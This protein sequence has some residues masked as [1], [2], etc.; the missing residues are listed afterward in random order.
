MASSAQ[1]ARCCALHHFF[2]YY[3]LQLLAILI[4]SSTSVSHGSSYSGLGAARNGTRHRDRGPHELQ[5]GHAVFAAVPTAW[6]TTSWP[7]A[8]YGTGQLHSSPEAEVGTGVDSNAASAPSVASTTSTTSLS[9]EARYDERRVRQHMMHTRKLLQTGNAGGDRAALLAQKN[10]ITNQASIS[11]LTSWTADGDPCGFTFVSCSN[12][13]VSMLSMA[14][15]GLQG[16]LAKELGSLAALSYLELS[17]NQLSGTIPLQLESASFLQFLL[18]YQNQ[19]SGTIPPELQSL[20]SLTALYLYN[21]QLSGTIPTA[22]GAMA[23]M[24]YLILNGNGLSGTIPPELGSLSGLLRL[25]LS[26][27]QLSG[28]IPPELGSLRSLEWLLL[29]GNKLSG[30][31]PSALKS[32]SSLRFLEISG[33]QLSGTIPTELVSLTALS[34]LVL[35]SNLLSGTILPLRNFTSLQILDLSNNQLSGT[36]PDMSS[37]SSL[38]LSKNQLSG[39]I[40]RLPSTGLGYL[41]LSQNQL[42]G[43]IPR[44]LGIGLEWLYLQENRLVG[45]VP[46]NDGDAEINGFGYFM[47]AVNVAFNPWICGP[48]PNA[49]IIVPWPGEVNMTG[50]W[51][52]DCPLDTGASTPRPP[53]PLPPL[54][55]PPRPRSPPLFGLESDRAALLAQKDAFTDRYQERLFD[56]TIDRNPCGFTFVDCYD[57]ERVDRLIIFENDFEGTIVRQLGSLEALTI[58]ALN[59]NRLSGTIP[60]ELGSLSS[61]ATLGMQRNLKLS[62]TIPP[63]LQSL[64]SLGHLL[65]SDNQLSGTIPPELGTLAFLQELYLGGTSLSGT[66]PPELGSLTSLQHLSLYN[67]QL[68]GTIPDLSDLSLSYLDM[69]QNQLS[70]T[71]PWLAHTRVLRHLDLSRNQ[72]SGTIPPLVY[73]FR[74]ADQAQSFVEYVYLQENRLVGTV[75]LDDKGITS[76]VDVNVAFNPWICG[77]NEIRAQTYNKTGTWGLTCPVC[78]DTSS[79]LDL[80]WGCTLD[81]PS[82][83]NNNECSLDTG[84][85]TPRPP[86]PPPSPPP[87]SPPPPLNSPPRPRSPPLFGLAPPEASSPPP[88][89]ASSPPPPVAEMCSGSEVLLAWEEIEFRLATIIVSETV[90]LNP[91]YV[92]QSGTLC[93]DMAVCSVGG[94]AS[95]CCPCLE[96]QLTILEGPDSV[97]DLSSLIFQGC[98]SIG[99]CSLDSYLKLF[100][101]C[102]YGARANALLSAVGAPF[103]PPASSLPPRLAAPP[104]PAV[105]PPVPQSIPSGFVTDPSTPWPPSPPLPP[106]SP[107]PAPKSPPRSPSPPLFSPESDR[108]ALL[109]QRDAFTDRYQ[110]WLDDWTIDGNPCGFSYVDCSCGFIYVDCPITNFGRVDRLLLSENQFEGTIV[111]QLGSL[112]A[113]QILALGGNRLSGTIPPEL[114]SLSSLATLMME[115]NL[116]LSGTIPSELQSLASL[117]YL[118]LSDN[119]L[120]GTIPPELGALAFLYH[121]DLG[122]TLLSGTIPPELGSLTSLEYLDLSDTQLSGTIPPELGSLRSLQILWISDTVKLSGTFPPELGSSSLRQLD[123]S[124]N[125][126][127]GT[128]PAGLGS[129]SSLSDLHLN[130]NRIL[131]TIPALRSF[132]TLSRLKLYSNQLSGTIPDLSAH[133]RLQHID[134]S[135][136]Q[137]SGAIPP[138]SHM[139]GLGH[140]DLSRNQLSGTIPSLVYIYR[141]LGWIKVGVSDYVYLQENRLVGTV[142]LDDKNITSLVAVNVAFN[143]WICGGNEIRAQ[144]YNK[145]GTWGLTCPVCFDTASVSDLDWGCTLNAPVCSDNNACV[146]LTEPDCLCPEAISAIFSMAIPLSTSSPLVDMFI[147]DLVG[148]LQGLEDPSQ[149]V[150]L[151]LS[152]GRTIAELAFV[153][154]GKQ[155]SFPAEKD[156]HILLA[157]RNGQV[158][159][160]DTYGLISIQVPGHDPVCVLPPVT[161]IGLLGATSEGGAPFAGPQP[162]FSVNT[163]VSGLLTTTYVDVQFSRPCQ[164]VGVIRDCGPSGCQLKLGSN[165]TLVAGID[166]TH[167]AL[168]VTYVETDNASEDVSGALANG[169]AIDDWAAGSRDSF[170]LNVTIAE[171]ICRDAL[172]IASTASE[173]FISDKMTASGG[174]RENKLVVSL[175]YTISPSCGLGDRGYLRTVIYLGMCCV[176]H[177]SRDLRPMFPGDTCIASPE[178]ADSSAQMTVHTLSFARLAWDDRVRPRLM[179]PVGSFSRDRRVPVFVDLSGEV[180]RSFNASA[181]TVTAGY[182]MDNITTSLDGTWFNVTLVIDE[183]ATAIISLDEGALYDGLSGAPSRRSNTLSITHVPGDALTD[184]VAEVGVAIKAVVG[185]VAVLNTMAGALSSLGM[186]SPVGAIPA[187]PATTTGLLGGIGHL[188]TIAMIANLRMELPDFFEQTTARWRW[189]NL[190]F[191]KPWDGSVCSPKSVEKAMA[192]V[193]TN[194]TAT[195]DIGG[196]GPQEGGQG[197]GAWAWLQNGTS[198]APVV[199]TRPDE[200]SPSTSQVVLMSAAC[201]WDIALQI[202][203]WAVILIVALLLIH[204]LVIYG[205][206]YKFPHAAS[207]ELLRFPRIELYLLVIISPPLSQAGS[208]LLSM[209]TPLAV[210]IGV[211]MLLAGPCA[212]L[213]LAIFILSRHVLPGHATEFQREEVPRPARPAWMRPLEHIWY[214]LFGTPIKAQWQD[215]EH[216]SFVA[217]FGPVFEIFKGPPHDVGRKTA[218]F[219]DEGSCFGRMMRWSNRMGSHWHAGYGIVD[220]FKRVFVAFM[221]GLSG[222]ARSDGSEDNGGSSSQ[223]RWGA[224]VQVSTVL[225]VLVVQLAIVV[226]QRP[227]IDRFMQAAETLSV[228]CEVQLFVIIFLILG[229][230]GDKSRVSNALKVTMQLSIVCN[231]LAQLYASVVIFIGGCKAFMRRLAQARQR[232]NLDSLRAHGQDALDA[233]SRLGKSSRELLREWVLANSGHG[234]DDDGVEAHAAVNR[235]RLGSA[236]QPE[237]SGELTSEIGCT[238]VHS[239][240]QASPWVQRPGREQGNGAGPDIGWAEAP[241]ACPKCSARCQ[242]GKGYQGAFMAEHGASAANF[243]LPDAA[244]AGRDTSNLYAVNPWMSVGA[245]RPRTTPMEGLAGK[246]IVSLPSQGYWPPTPPLMMASPTIFDATRNSRVD[247]AIPH[248][249]NVAGDAPGRHQNH[250]LADEGG[251]AMASLGVEQVLMRDKESADRESGTVSGEVPPPHGAQ[252]DNGDQQSLSDTSV[253]RTDTLLNGQQAAAGFPQRPEATAHNSGPV[254]QELPLARDQLSG[255]RAGTGFETDK[256]KKRPRTASD[257]RAALRS[258]P[259]PEMMLLQT[260]GLF[261]DL[262]ALAR[263]LPTPAAMDALADFM[264]VALPQGMYCNGIAHHSVT[265]DPTPQPVNDDLCA[266]FQVFLAAQWPVDNDVCAFSHAGISGSGLPSRRSIKLHARLSISEDDFETHMAQFLSSMSSQLNNNEADINIVHVSAATPPTSTARSLRRARSEDLDASLSRSAT[267]RQV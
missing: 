82:C 25:D 264:H 56:W 209:R 121:L 220:I 58:L 95:T 132:T 139:Q 38:K 233:V 60:P 51:G 215:R 37:M 218:D 153:P 54:N 197:Q 69:S 183:S 4:A 130:T 86:S 251:L 243:P 185:L 205:W 198:T 201:S 30:T 248:P 77:A 242:N 96:K 138:L 224:W 250:V 199:I 33:T 114:G 84:A 27:G 9:E 219:D 161:H 190:E 122:G 186:L 157:L 140:V 262:H 134:M 93:P 18:L 148:A 253:Q 181:F 195:S 3:V 252:D 45:T 108:A 260:E 126:L 208:F 162:T 159:L 65:L 109:A 50:T 105:I 225:C 165:E 110:E 104:P 79:A 88:P 52:A 73:I 206:R 42:S 240:G 232:I 49:V 154:P 137:L 124:R 72:L 103:P 13:R 101:Q 5:A 133:I 28:S 63:E 16:T 7:V 221:L 8:T 234:D 81:A 256:G 175:R 216:Y 179:S 44:V 212:L 99:Q 263:A 62:G 111:R 167:H 2:A 172:G 55:S 61:L 87:G 235:I 150:I 238:C 67:N 118:A 78:F 66:I 239:K 1:G 170:G 207:P 158:Q 120:S 145:T 46:L 227:F 259:S 237:H 228:A 245:S 151:S 204:A 156:E 106:P 203:F 226:R 22:L 241:A 26:N 213:Y 266:F 247:S 15:S 39:T 29:S 117:E 47:V 152:P 31:I 174:K 135:Q 141:P 32:L 125:Q 85:S 230:W 261:V 155:H 202:L 168:H 14:E 146:V 188:Q 143:P 89:K 48:V 192:S 191:L 147:S 23:S 43:T 169:T 129:L 115:R 20:T 131:G 34:S 123:L 255:E 210:S 53:S 182:V 257:T 265:A 196:G 100:D 71:I 21:N 128:I 119:P 267:L 178:Y 193:T 236:G 112:E 19:L 244:T 11:A 258:E 64:A 160:P 98:T 113:L 184:A 144:T 246:E 149:V 173:L 229:G 102:G 214:A 91:T 35:F 12:G 211:L 166:E 189:L 90:C 164:G 217:R 36:I 59:G 194:R 222:P 74:F 187:G 41:D 231:L 92:L 40:P 70:G 249:L 136:N 68:S 57:T 163:S 177:T 171:G 10:A 83:I 200:R 127:S 17:R 223:S 97:G 176:V 116:K 254:L 76:L 75:P 24:R 142:P 107:P 180:V 80:D 94:A 6:N